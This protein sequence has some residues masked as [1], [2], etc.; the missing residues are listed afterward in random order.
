MELFL[1][2][3]ERVGLIIVFAFLMSRWRLFRGVLFQDQ[4][5]KEKIW[6]I[7]IFSALSIVSSYTGIKIESG[8]INPLNQMI[9]S[10]INAEEAIANTRLIGV[11]IAGIFGGPLVGVSVG[12]IAGIHRVTLGGFTAVAC[13]I[14]TILAGF[15]TG[16]LS[17]QLK[18][19]QTFSYKKA[20]IIGICAETLQMIVIL[21]VAKPFEQALQLV[22]LIALPMIFMNAFGILIFFII[23]KT[24][25]DEEER[26]KALQT[27]QAFSIAQQTIEHFRKGLNE[28]SCRTVAEIIK[29]EIKV[30][31]VAITD[32]NGI[33]AHV[34]VGEDHHVIHQEIITALTKRVLVEGRIITATSAKEINCPHEDCPLSAAIVLPLK[35]QHKTVGTLK[36]YF[37]NVSSLTGAKK[38]LAE[39]LSR[40][41]SSQLEYAEIEQ[42]RKLL[43]DAEIKA[44]Q[45]QVHP[46][47]FFNSLNTISS[48]IRTDADEARALLIK[49]STFFRSNLQGARQMLIPLK[50]EIDHVEAY[51]SIE[52]KRFPNRYDV[53]FH[54]DES[55]Y[56]VQIP[57]FTLQPLVEN[58]IHHAFKN[59][60]EGKIGVKVQ[61]INN[62]LLL[63]TEDNGCGMREEQIKQ[64][65]KTI[66]QSEQ[67]TGTA[68]WNI[69]QRIHE[70]YGTEADFHISSTL[71]VGTKIM[72]QLPL[73]ATR[74]E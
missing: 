57:P 65:G 73:K 72:I 41:F 47:F 25:I 56:D 66:M 36:L 27:H 60:K 59:R 18:I 20:V 32:T 30:D 28:E 12:V 37:I 15:I 11:A 49:L 61:R 39:G 45:A 54:L 46:H 35:V 44:L 16:G 14:S 21:I 70:I 40:L 52:Q 42:Q 17:K 43:K 38:E 29:R 50:N 24:F 4:G 58:A 10:T 64:L 55:L 31:A 68:L 5:V 48:L 53:K 3:L 8:A 71:D 9:H 1:F 63:L 34:G 22:S 51:L 13:G 67:G 2:M 6:L 62:K 74:W 19:R 26:T 7:I 23:I 69:Y 33:L